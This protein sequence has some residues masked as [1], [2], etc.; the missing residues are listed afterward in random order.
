MIFGWMISSSPYLL[1]GSI[2]ISTFI[3]EDAA[4][5][6]AALIATGGMISPSAAFLALFAGIYAGD[7]G[8]Y[9][10][11]AAAHC[12]KRARAFLGETRIATAQH[13]LERRATAA[14]IGARFVPGSRLPI[15]TV[16]GFLGVPFALFASITGIASLVWSAAVFTL[17]YLFGAHITDSFGAAR[18]VIAVPVLLVIAFG[19][20]LIARFS[21]HRFLAEP[22]DV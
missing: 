2:V 21:G 13:W 1:A 7:I 20:G 12:S 19:P 4:I 22:S 6:Y 3:L 16:S 14:L 9:F 10:L 8:L 5:V 17:V 11:G 18:Y 15:Y